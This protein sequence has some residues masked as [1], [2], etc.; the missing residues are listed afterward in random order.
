LILITNLTVV[1][2]DARRRILS[3]GAIL[4]DGERILAVGKAAEL[5]R[6]CRGSN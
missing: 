1:T 4:L 6:F 2:M 3:E 5:K